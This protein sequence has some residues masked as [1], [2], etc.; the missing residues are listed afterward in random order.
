VD[1]NLDISS[2]STLRNTDEQSVRS[3]NGCR[4]TDSLLKIVEQVGTSGWGQLG[5]HRLCYGCVDADVSVCRQ[6]CRSSH[7]WLLETR[8]A[9]DLQSQAQTSSHKPNKTYVFGVVLVVVQA[10][11]CWWMS[12]AVVLS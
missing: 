1:D 6:P 3:L 12:I 9:V 5:P 11:G 4:V 8:A 7:A 10:T 2:V